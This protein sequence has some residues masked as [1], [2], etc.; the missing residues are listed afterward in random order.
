MLLYEGTGVLDSLGSAALGTCP[1]DSSCHLAKMQLHS[2]DR[3]ASP[4]PIRDAL[5][6]FWSAGMSERPPGLGMTPDSPPLAMRYYVMNLCWRHAGMVGF[7]GSLRKPTPHGSLRSTGASSRL[8]K[9][10]TSTGRLCNVQKS[11]SS[12]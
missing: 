4:I 12:S 11:S 10:G 1:R 3:R 7:V 5:G 6:R 8:T 2:G 9:S